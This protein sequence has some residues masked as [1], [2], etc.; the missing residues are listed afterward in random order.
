VTLHPVPLFY[1]GGE[2]RWVDGDGNQVDRLSLREYNEMAGAA[3]DETH[4]YPRS[5]WLS[6]DV[7]GC[8]LSDLSDAVVGLP[9]RREVGCVNGCGFRGYRMA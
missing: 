2:T 5:N 9:P 1:D 8:D 6:C 3:Y 7:C 4:R